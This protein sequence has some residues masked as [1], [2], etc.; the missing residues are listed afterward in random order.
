MIQKRFQIVD[1]D[2]TNKIIVKIVTL[3]GRNGFR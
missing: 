2:R 3:T 1:N